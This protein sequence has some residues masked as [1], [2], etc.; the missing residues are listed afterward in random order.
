MPLPTLSM[1]LMNSGSFTAL[2]TACAQDRDDRLRH[3]GLG[4]HAVPLVVLGVV[5]ELLQGRQ[6]G[7]A[8]RRASRPWCRSGA[9]CRRAPAGRRPRDARRAAPRDCRARRSA[10]ARRP[11]SA[12]GASWC[13]SPSARSRSQDAWCRRAR[14]RHRRSGP[15]RFLASSISS[16]KFFQGWLA[17]TNS[18]DGSAE[19]SAIGANCSRV[20]LGGRPNT[21]IDRG[22]ERELR[23]RDRDGV[24]V[25]RRIGD[26]HGADQRR[27][28]G[29]V[30]NHDRLAEDAL[31][32]RRERAR[33]GVGRAA[34][35]IAEQDGDRLDWVFVLR[36]RRPA[37]EA[38]EDEKPEACTDV[39]LSI[40]FQRLALSIRSFLQA[41]RLRKT[42]G[43]EADGQQQERR[44]PADATVIGRCRKIV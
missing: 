18:T 17:L 4:E 35:R 11:R 10:P 13:R 2:A 37:G 3:L 23:G 25:G 26:L 5:A 27:G 38:H 7:E 15:G 42:A 9:A 40:S 12:D 34:R 32:H 28:A 6:V 30:L 39:T 31:K 22:Q 29:A 41:C 44:S 16:W 43:S 24:A 8:S 36:L 19:T 14:R 1:A 33:G 21:P 20:K